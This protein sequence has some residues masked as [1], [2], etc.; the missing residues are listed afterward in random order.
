MVNSSE[1]SCL[2]IRFYRH[3]WIFCF[4]ILSMEDEWRM[5]N[6]EWWMLKDDDFKLLRGFEDEQIDGQMNKLTD[7]SE[8]RVAFAIE[9]SFQMWYFPN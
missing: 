4:S 1:W 2:K 5:M 3:E 9:K 8:C 6:D 7:I